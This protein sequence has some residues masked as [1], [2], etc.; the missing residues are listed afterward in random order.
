MC[1]KIPISGTFSTSW[2]LESTVCNHLFG[3]RLFFSFLIFIQ[4]NSVTIRSRRIPAN[5]VTFRKQYFCGLAFSSRAAFCF[6]KI[7]WRLWFGFSLII[8][9][10][11]Y[12]ETFRR[13]SHNVNKFTY[14]M[15]N[16]PKCLICLKHEKDYNYSLQVYF[17]YVI[18]LSKAVGLTLLFSTKLSFYFHSNSLTKAQRE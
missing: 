1:G 13:G 4:N 7:T 5:S 11:S 10:G 9:R 15:K 6:F 12:K 17:N 3:R 16:S 18:R 14:L 2:K 8:L